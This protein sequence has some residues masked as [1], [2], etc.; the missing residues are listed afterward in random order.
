[1]RKVLVNFDRNGF[2]YTL[3]RATGELLTAEPFVFVNWA[4]GIDLK[5]GRPIEIPVK[6]AS[7]EKN[8][9]DICPSAM[10]GKDQQPVAYSPRTCVVYVPTYN[11]GLDFEG[12]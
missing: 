4:K 9:K 1:M 10:G 8:T 2:C 6:R 12:V 5:T 7:A 11:L 3:D